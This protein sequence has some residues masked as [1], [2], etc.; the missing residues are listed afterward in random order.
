MTSLG[1]HVLLFLFFLF[2]RAI[3][4]HND[5]I[6]IGTFHL[7]SY[8]R[9]LV[10]RGSHDS[11]KDSSLRSNIPFFTIISAQNLNDILRL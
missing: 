7:Q 6:F 8:N 11:E 2:G 1:I 9:P 5:N 3:L 4:L 10:A